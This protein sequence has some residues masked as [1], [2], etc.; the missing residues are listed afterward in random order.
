[1]EWYDANPEEVP[2]FPDPLDLL[3]EELQG[4]LDTALDAL[5]TI[6]ARRGAAVGAS[7]PLGAR[8]APLVAGRYRA[9]LAGHHQEKRAA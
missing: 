7:A 1:M 6:A 9:A 4:S 5:P 3:S 2:D 8:L